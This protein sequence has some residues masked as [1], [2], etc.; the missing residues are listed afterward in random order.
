MTQTPW[1]P[2]V[3]EASPGLRK[4]CPSARTQTSAAPGVSTEVP[5]SPLGTGGGFRGARPSPRDLR[6]YVDSLQERDA[7]C[8]N[9]SARS[10]SR[11]VSH[12]FAQR[13]GWDSTRPRGEPG[14]GV[15]GGR[16]GWRGHSPFSRVCLFARTLRKV[17]GGDKSRARHIPAG[18]AAAG[19]GGSRGDGPL[20]PFYPLP[21][22]PT[23]PS[24][25]TPSSP[26]P[27]PHSL[28]I[29]SPPSI[30]TL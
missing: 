26:P 1:F 27:I 22:H 25:H 18:E 13:A 19:A 14:R 20:P 10:V 24:S 7:G 29:P 2:G 30:H 21:P 23:S 11:Q 9:S 6:S 28:T 12:R 4:S 15:G 5:H 17:C 8:H 3:T 16:E